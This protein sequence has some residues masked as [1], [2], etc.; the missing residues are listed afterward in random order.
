MASILSPIRPLG[1]MEKGV[2][3]VKLQDGSVFEGVPMM[4][5][6]AVFHLNYMYNSDLD[7]RKSI[8]ALEVSS[9][10]NRRRLRVDEL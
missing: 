4:P 9:V 6:Y 2:K 8:L 3:K 10:L 7:P 5:P 1:G